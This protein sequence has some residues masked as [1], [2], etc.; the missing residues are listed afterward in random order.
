MYYVAQ[1]EW[2]RTSVL[3]NEKLN[4]SHFLNKKK[5]KKNNKKIKPGL[6]IFVNHV[7]FSLWLWAM[8]ECRIVTYYDL[9]ANSISNLR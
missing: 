8:N 5:E 3:F 6:G 7:F 9:T 4:Y 2:N 1:A